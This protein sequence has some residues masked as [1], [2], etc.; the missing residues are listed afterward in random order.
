MSEISGG[1]D[2]EKEIPEEMSERREEGG[3][4]EEAGKGEGLEKR[5]DDAS[6]HEGS[7]SPVHGFA[8]PGKTDDS[9]VVR[10]KMCQDFG[11]GQ[12]SLITYS[13]LGQGLNFV[14][15]GEFGGRH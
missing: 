5:D 13:F 9:L 12:V 14:L 3:Q 7:S 8:T 10:A 11:L 15:T 1:G 6:R 2:T 4:E